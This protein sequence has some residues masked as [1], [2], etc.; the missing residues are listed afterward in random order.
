MMVSPK[1]LALFVVLFL[2]KITALRGEK[3]NYEE[4]KEL[5]FLDLGISVVYISTFDF[6]IKYK[7][8]DRLHL[9]IT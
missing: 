7:A 1:I 8:L 2:I 6:F 9:D 3:L 5:Y 4:K